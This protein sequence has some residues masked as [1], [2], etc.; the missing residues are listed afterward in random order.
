M[1]EASAIWLPRAIRFATG[2]SSLSVSWERVLGIGVFLNAVT[3][4]RLT[5]KFGT[6]VLTN[7]VLWIIPFTLILW[8]AYRHYLSS[9]RTASPDVQALAFRSRTNYGQTLLELS[10]KQPLMLV[11]LRYKGCP[12][13]R[14]A[15]SD[16]SA[17]RP[18]IEARGCQLVFV[19][20]EHDR[21]VHDFLLRYALHDLPRIS[22]PKRTLYR[23]FGLKLGSLWQ[24]LGPLTWWRGI[25]AMLLEGHGPGWLTSNPFQ[26]PGVFAVH[27]GNILRSFI[28]QLPSDRAELSAIRSSSC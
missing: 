11:F 10:R 19:H 6:T 9:Q 22:D 5:W 4:H 3:A 25:S 7:D 20:M 14:E 1:W 16:L 17:L 26:M 8:R 21:A 13:C 18:A 27:R 23:A 28:H 15:L 2:L 24:L 12:F